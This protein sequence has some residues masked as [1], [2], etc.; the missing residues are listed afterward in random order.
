MPGPVVGVSGEPVVPA[1]EEFVML[2]AAMAHF[3][4]SGSR[5]DH[6]Q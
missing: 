2:K 6:L 1:R 3:A 5:A 4:V